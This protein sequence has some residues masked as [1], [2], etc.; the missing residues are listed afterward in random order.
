M[1]SRFAGPAYGLAGA[2]AVFVIA[3]RVL[4]EAGIVWYEDGVG[5]GL[6]AHA[7][8]VMVR[9]RVHMNFPGI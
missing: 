9:T 5:C 6:D 3:A 4:V 8:I 1:T 2:G 7:L